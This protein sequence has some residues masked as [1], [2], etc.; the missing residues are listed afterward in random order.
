MSESNTWSRLREGLLGYE[1]LIDLSRVENVVE[2][3]MPDVNFCSSGREG[4]I[5]LKHTAT[6]PARAS[7]PVFKTGGLRK[8]QE[9]WIDRRTRRGGRVFIYAQIGEGLILVHGV[10]AKQF[11]S[12]TLSQLGRIA[13]WKHAGPNPDWKELFRALIE[14][15]A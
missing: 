1:P 12:M 11:N 9:V 3:G 8:E 6:V 4:W 14:L 5:E 10:Y 13:R 2:N 15:P 7:T